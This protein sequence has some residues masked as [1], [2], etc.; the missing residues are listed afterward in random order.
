MT[1]SIELDAPY[2]HMLTNDASDLGLPVE[3]LA[4]KIL[5]EQLESRRNEPRTPG[6]S[7]FRTAM[8]ASFKQYDAAYRRLAQ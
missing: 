5:C 3:E 6:D 1:I 4:G 7:E 8:E 2:S